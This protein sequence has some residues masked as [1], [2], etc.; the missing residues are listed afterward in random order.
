MITIQPY[1]PTDG[2]GNGPVMGHYSFSFL[3]DDNVQV[4]RFTKCRESMMDHFMRFVTNP[5]FYGKGKPIPSLNKTRILVAFTNFPQLG[6]KLEQ[7]LDWLH[8]I[9]SKLGL[10]P[11][12]MD[13]VEGLPPA[14][15]TVYLIEGS[16]RW[17]LSPPMLSM[18][19]LILRSGASHTIGAPAINLF[20]KTST[21]EDNTRVA[22]FLDH[23]LT[24]KYWK[25]FGKDQALNWNS[26]FDASG[27]SPAYDASGTIPYLG[28][29]AFVYRSPI[30]QSD[31]DI[32]AQNKRIYPHWMWIEKHSQEGI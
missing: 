18:F 1:A 5:E 12:T 24:K 19:L 17:Q 7:A 29:R 10:I 32:L 13:I 26:K 28:V 11:T 31:P 9:E 27:A 14:L 8:Q 25:V 3:S 4:V 22:I 15:G 23:L 16:K 21:L 2:Y 6:E 20:E 30:E